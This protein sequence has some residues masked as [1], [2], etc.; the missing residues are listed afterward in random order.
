VAPN[1]AGF[2]EW[3]LTHAPGCAT[4]CELDR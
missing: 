2:F 1:S 4:C 3:R